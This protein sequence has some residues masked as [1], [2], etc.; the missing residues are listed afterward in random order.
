VIMDG[1]GFVDIMQKLGVE[2]R[3]II[4]GAHKAMLDPFSPSKPDEKQFMQTLI[5][6][7]H[8]QFIAAV[9]S[10]RGARLKETPDMFSGLVWT[11][12]ESLKLGIADAVGTQDSV[13]KALGAEK[14]VDFTE[15]SRLIDKLA[16]K[17]GASFGQS[18]TGLVKQV[19]LR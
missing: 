13:A 14:L 17:L 10:G 16:G 9:K 15:Q 5:E 2:R 19:S 11:G 18:I 4:A 12:E 3:L 8:K 1:F 7:V 6:Q